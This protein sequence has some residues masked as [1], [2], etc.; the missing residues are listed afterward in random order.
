M[1]ERV[2]DRYR[3]SRSN[4]MAT[5]LTRSVAYLSFKRIVFT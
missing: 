5:V 2:C 1:I 4:P 3:V